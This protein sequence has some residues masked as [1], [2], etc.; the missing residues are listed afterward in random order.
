MQLFETKADAGFVTK[1]T[2][3][4][5]SIHTHMHAYIDAYEQIG[6]LR[7]EGSGLRIYKSMC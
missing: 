3:K 1:H 2:Y 4:H 7:V 6:S 5:T